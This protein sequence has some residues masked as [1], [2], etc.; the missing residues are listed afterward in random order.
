MLTPKCPPRDFRVGSGPLS[1][2]NRL[3]RQSG[4][5]REGK[6]AG[7][8][9]KKG[10][11]VK[12]DFSCYNND[13][14]WLGRQGSNLGSRDQN[15]MPYHLATP[16]Y[17]SSRRW[18]TSAR[19]HMAGGCPRTS[20]RPMEQ[21]HAGAGFSQAPGSLE[22]GQ[23]PLLRASALP[24]IYVRLQPSGVWRSLVA[25]LVR[26]EGVAGSNPATPTIT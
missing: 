23:P 25:H 7:N 2:K 17:R 10:G 20:I 21:R 11:S 5:I 12:H 9:P 19:L 18:P 16:Q 13:L 15:P 3:C 26:D 22:P 24:S 4:A 8:R 6:L 14:V 1:A